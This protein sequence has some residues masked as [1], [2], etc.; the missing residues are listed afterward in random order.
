MAACHEAEQ[1]KSLADIF[2]EIN[3]DALAH[4]TGY[5]DLQK[6]TSTIGHRLTGSENG[7]KAEAFAFDLLKK[8]GYDDV[9]FMDFEVEAWARKSVQLEITIGDTVL[10]PEVVSLAH[11]PVKS[12]V[13][14]DLVFAG[15]CL[16]KDLDKLG[17][18]IKGRI[19]IANIGLEP[20]DSTE[21]NLHRSE[22]TALAMEYGAAGLI[23]YNK[24]P[25]RILLTGTASV[26]GELNAIPAV[27]I[28]YE[29]GTALCNRLLAGEKATAHIS[30]ENT[31]DVIKARNVVAT[32]PGS[33]LSDEIIVV[34]GHLDSWDLATGA[35]DNGI[36]SFT[37]IDI[38]RTFKSLGLKPKRTIKFVLFMGEEQGLLG[39]KYMAGQM[40]KDGS[41]NKVRYVLNL[42]M[43]GN[44]IGLGTS[45]R[46]EMKDF[47]LKVGGL[48]QQTDSVFINKIS[49]GAGLH[50]DH[51]P[52]M[53]EGIPVLR[54]MSNM[55]DSIYKY[56][57][58]N[59]DDFNLVNK[60]DM[61][62]GTRFS[63]MALYALADADTIPALKL[64]DEDTRAFFIQQGLKEE[65]VIGKT[66]RWEE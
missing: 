59:G 53:L 39:S 28:A 6:A 58:S 22:K 29:D 18:A 33:D 66:W 12:D 45:G 40:V 4:S 24:V 65:M 63:S 50:S 9:A 26:T 32:L 51:F 62:N 10:R 38:A 47:L 61:V 7:A 31:S 54:T 42:D 3:A 41:I 44:P 34:G 57:H 23:L 49:E 35:I 43:A 48:I 37:V 52:F 21:K 25:G 8:Y 5:D 46:P 17:E 64:S 60:N 19:L 27:N 16:K 20:A 14:S 30:M 1:A 55:N 36:G 56:Y 11:S 13:E 2:N 15:S